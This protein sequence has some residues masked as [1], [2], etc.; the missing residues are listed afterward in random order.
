M[1]SDSDTK[2]A[3]L[4]S[5]FEQTREK[6]KSDS[7][8]SIA[9]SI[10][11]A[12][13]WRYQQ[14]AHYLRLYSEKD[15]LTYCGD[16]MS[17]AMRMR[18]IQKINSA[19]ARGIINPTRNIVNSAK[20]MITR[21][22]PMP[23]VTSEGA[24]WEE[25]FKSVK[26]QNFILATLHRER[27]YELA[28]KAV[29]AGNIYGTGGMQVYRTDNGDK[30]YSIKLDIIHPYELFID[31]A[32]GVMG[33]PQTI[34]KSR[35]ISKKRLAMIYDDKKQLIE[36]AQTIDLNPFRSTGFEMIDVLEIWRLPSYEGADDG[37][38]ACVI[39]GGI[40]N[41]YDWVRMRHPF[42]FYRWCESPQ[43]FYGDGLPYELQTLQYELNSITKTLSDN[44]R[45]GAVL[46]WMAQE[47]TVIDSHITNQRNAPIIKYKGQTP[48]QQVVAPSFSPDA[49]QYKESIKSEMY[50]QSGVPMF[51]SQSQRVPNK[52]G[53]AIELESDSESLR[54][55]P[56]VQ[57]YEQM[58][59]DVGY[60]ILEEARD[61]KEAHGDASVVFK[62]KYGAET[63]RWSDIAAPT[64]QLQISMYSTAFLGTTPRAVVN[65]VEYQ[66]QRGFI[67]NEQAKAAMNVPYDNSIQ[68]QR[69]SAPVNYIEFIMEKMLMTG[70][71]IQPA[72]YIDLN[73]AKQ[74]TQEQIQFCEINKVPQ[75]RIDVLISF[76]DLVM[77]EIGKAQE[78]AMAEQQ[79]MQA[80]VLPQQ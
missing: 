11:S 54:F 55:K 7:I 80:Q 21:N 23:T 9:Q 77:A 59:I 34:I 4:D 74:M 36:R 24:N 41:E 42:G 32:D 73:L 40:L 38:Y 26:R 27:A 3:D 79:A 67:T 16:S 57:S 22:R 37:K 18:S 61:I 6:D 14:Y 58:F 46:R 25:D 68:E 30:S 2:N 15:W 49:F 13:S 47:G 35:A 71:L 39:D 52:S 66:L 78:G 50:N 53:R 60:N 19:A 62:G 63:I 72:A 56:T 28:D 64:N 33:S 75:E 76:L 17:K 43:Q 45:N 5:W 29:L 51:F 1:A 44:I 70:E 69:S 31:D 12:Q 10:A 20:S 48:P 8:I 65:N